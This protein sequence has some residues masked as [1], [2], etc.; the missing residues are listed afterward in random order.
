MTI[1]TVQNRATGEIVHAYT[2]DGPD[3]SATYPYDTYNHIPQPVVTTPPV[4]LLSKLEYL[5]RFEQAERIGIRAAAPSSPALADYLQL[6]D[7]AD[8][9]NLDHPDVAAALTM[10]TA[11]GLLAEGRAAEI[12]A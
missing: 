10:L 5:R 6:L 4:R 2:A 11:A 3:H 1:Y 12:L 9:V 8:D 7:M